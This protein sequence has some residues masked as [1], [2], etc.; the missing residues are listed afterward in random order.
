MKYLGVP[1][2]LS[3]LKVIYCKGLV[4]RITSKVQH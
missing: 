3:R 4:D 2:I 1:F